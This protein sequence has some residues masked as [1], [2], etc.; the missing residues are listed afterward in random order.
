MGGGRSIQ[1]IADLYNVF[2]DN[3]PLELNN[4]YGA[5]TGGSPDWQ[6]PQLI[7]PGRLAKFGFQLDF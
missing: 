6:R 5:S 3:T 7:V 1:L 2:N 4:Q